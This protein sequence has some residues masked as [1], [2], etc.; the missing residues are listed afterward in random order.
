HYHSMEIFAHYDIIDR[1]GTRLAQGSKASF[2]L[3]DSACDQGVHPQFN[4]KG[5]A[6]Q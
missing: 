2:C 5:Y 4:C 1:N 3:E 6:E